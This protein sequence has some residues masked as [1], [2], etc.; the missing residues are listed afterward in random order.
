MEF[1]RIAMLLLVFVVASFAVAGVVEYLSNSV[2]ANVT[3]ASPIELTATALDGEGNPVVLD[4]ITAY[5]NET[6]VITLNSDNLSN[7]AQDG[8]Y[9]LDF[10]PEMSVTKIVANGNELVSSETALTEY[11]IE[12][13]GI[14][15]HGS[16]VMVVEITMA[17]NEPGAY[18][19]DATYEVD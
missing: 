1:K 9:A 3:T 18:A 13:D 12:S 6:I 7:A 5:S 17:N 14:V 10:T 16:E 4:S 15:A 8:V 2:S 11:D 19:I